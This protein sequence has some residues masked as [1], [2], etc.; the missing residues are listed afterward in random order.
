MEL[1]L[2]RPHLRGL[3]GDLIASAYNIT[4]KTYLL[5]ANISAAAAASGTTTELYIPRGVSGSPAVSGAATLVNVTSWPDGSRSV[6]AQPSAAG[7]LFN[8]SISHAGTH[9]EVAGVE[10]AV[11][12]QAEVVAPW[13]DILKLK[14][15]GGDKG[16]T[17]F[18][19]SSKLKFADDAGAALV[20]G[21][22]ETASAAAAAV[23]F[24]RAMG[25][26]LDAVY[27]VKGHCEAWENAMG[28]LASSNT[29]DGAL[30]AY[31]ESMRAVRRVIQEL[32]LQ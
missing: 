4:T 6:F 18:A 27:R 23:A 30:A 26:S 13:R 32:G 22:D 21:F 5:Q 8:I 1:I 25:L 29:R 9:V 19:T 16:A 31:M 24:S 11:P 2:S 20:A 17:A 12:G 7:G 28:A 14:Y 15:G 10:A 3:V